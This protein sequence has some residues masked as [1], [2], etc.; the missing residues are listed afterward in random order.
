MQ[1]SSTAKLR[2]FS[3]DFK[4]KSA[5]Q[6]LIKLINDEN[7]FNGDHFGTESNHKSSNNA[8]LSLGVYL[9]IFGPCFNP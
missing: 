9:L 2:V 4:P 1:Q 5:F 3:K 6:G 8:K 7:A